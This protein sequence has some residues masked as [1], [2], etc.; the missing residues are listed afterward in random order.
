MNFD[1]I[2]VQA[3]G[4]GSRLEKQTR[5]KPK[6]MC[7]VDNFPIIFH[8]FNRFP[9]KRFIIIADYK[10]DVLESY[11]ETFAKVRYLVVRADGE[12][13]CSGISDAIS[14]IPERKSFMLIWSD[15]VLG[16]EDLFGDLDEGQY[17][18]L[19]GSFECRWSYKNNH[20]IEEKSTKYGV[21]G[22]FLFEGKEA[23]QEV[24]DDGEFVEWLQQKDISFKTVWLKGTREFGTLAD[25]K[26]SKT[27]VRSFN[28]LSI[29]VDRVVKEPVNAKGELLAERE[30]RW[31]RKVREFGFKNIPGIYQ[32]KP[33]IMERI[34]G[35]NPHHI[36][37]SASEKRVVLDRIVEALEQLHSNCH[38]ETDQF[39]LMEAYYG[40][41]MNRL[42]QVRHLIPYAD[43]KMIEING[44]LCRNIFFFQRDFKKLVSDRLSNTSFTLIHGDN[45]FS[46]TLVD[47]N[48]NVTFIDPRG[49]FGYTELYGD[50]RYDWAKL[51]YSVYG[52]YDAYNHGRFDLDMDH[53]KVTLE[54]QESGWEEL[55][56]Y[57][58]ERT[59]AGQEANVQL[60]HAILWLS[61]TTYIW[62]NYD[63][64]C[65]A[66]YRGLYLLNEFWDI[67][68]DLKTLHEETI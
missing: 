64:I 21:A 27:R 6:A 40:K 29:E 39:S 38:R 35:G 13:N 46:N 17:V 51:Y 48:L 47:S 28:R 25:L 44:K 43:E 58:L 59:S 16:E 9:D 60:I 52:S 3:G 24:P 23:L 8:L 36:E 15:L 22:L 65:G 31:Y 61:L 26:Q 53:G 19:S 56:D 10:A 12:G 1:Y 34:Q 62:E 4:R 20:F 18:G 33:L 7:T 54:V 2:V 42:N 37:L 55:S 32:E 66:F 11:L 5:N 14:F 57:L 67:S 50:I 63:A 41:T 30:L 45:T 68:T 49:Y